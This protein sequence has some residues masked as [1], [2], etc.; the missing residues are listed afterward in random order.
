VNTASRLESYRA[1][2]GEEDIQSCR[3]YIGEATAQA[4]DERYQVERVGELALKGK[5]RGVTVFSV[6]GL[7][8]PR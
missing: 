3:I 7:R 5:D 4:L 2:A 1:G 8:G 6:L